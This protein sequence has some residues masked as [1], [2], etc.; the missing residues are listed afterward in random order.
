[1]DCPGRC[2]PAQPVDRVR[3]S[4]ELGAN[5]Q[6]L[7]S[8]V[9]GIALATSGSGLARADALLYWIAITIAIAGTQ[10][11][12][13]PHRRCTCGRIHFRF[14]QEAGAR[15]GLSVADYICKPHLRRRVPPDDR[16]LSQI[17]VPQGRLALT[18][19]HRRR[20][21]ET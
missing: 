6:S 17:A 11:P 10:N 13:G 2:P 18:H 12:F 19:W 1:M 14:Y 21:R 16:N 3:E 15:K 8:A 9:E 7:S 5:S 4:C 20:N